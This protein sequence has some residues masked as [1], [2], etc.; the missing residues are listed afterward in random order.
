MNPS[1][2][3]DSKN[4]RRISISSLVVKS[5]NRVV[6]SMMKPEI[7]GVLKRNQTR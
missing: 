3:S 1:F 2:L 5:L 6:L 4:Y 7:E